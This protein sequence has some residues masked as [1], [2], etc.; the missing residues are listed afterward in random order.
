MFWLKLIIVF[1]LLNNL[2]SK[3][4]EEESDLSEIV[5]SYVKS[6]ITDLGTK[7]LSTQDVSIIRLNMF[8]ASKRQVNNLYADI[9]KIIP[10]KN[11]ILLAPLD[12]NVQ[13][14]MLRTSSLF[15][16]ISDFHDG[17]SSKILIAEKINQFTLPFIYLRVASLV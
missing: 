6:L 12:Q 5:S 11:P 10:D 14:C 4:V 16:L 9:C 15:I 2:E 1:L 3:F 8:N 17:V 13:D 7:R